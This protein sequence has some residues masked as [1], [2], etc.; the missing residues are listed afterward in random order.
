MK[1]RIVGVLAVL[2]LAGSVFL[3]AEDSKESKGKKPK[4]TKGQTESNSQGGK[5]TYLHEYGAVSL[6][7][8]VGSCYLLVPDNDAGNAYSSDLSYKD[9]PSKR[10]VMREGAEEEIVGWVYEAKSKT[11]PPEYKFLFL[12]VDP[13]DATN[14][15]SSYVGTSAEDKPDTVFKQYR[16]T[17]TA[18]RNSN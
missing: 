4:D 2:L 3:C 8:D 14:I 17:F 16:S 10:K 1:S 7:R 5:Q 18:H 9:G 13:S 15:K 12:A 6:K 11:F